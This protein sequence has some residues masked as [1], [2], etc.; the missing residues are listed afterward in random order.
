V[1]SNTQIIA[2]CQLGLGPYM[3]ATY[4]YITYDYEL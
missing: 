1:T 3:L 4:G 2:G